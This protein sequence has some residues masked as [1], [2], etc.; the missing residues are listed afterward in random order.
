MFYFSCTEIYC[1]RPMLFV[2]NAVF[3]QSHLRSG[4]RTKTCTPSDALLTSRL[5]RRTRGG[6]LVC[7]SSHQ[8]RSSTSLLLSATTTCWQRSIYFYLFFLMSAA[9]R[10]SPEE[11]TECCWLSHS[12]ETRAANITWWVFVKDFFRTQRSQSVTFAANIKKSIVLFE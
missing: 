5:P 6:V 2:S 12:V 8:P 3:M 4:K 9:S 10:H 7:R 11:E 1:Y